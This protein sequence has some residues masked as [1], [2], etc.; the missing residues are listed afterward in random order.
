[1]CASKCSVVIGFG[2]LAAAGCCNPFV[3][4]Q[5]IPL[6]RVEGKHFTLVP[7]LR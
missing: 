7:Q 4:F 6:G 1:M 5:Q 3:P 2:D